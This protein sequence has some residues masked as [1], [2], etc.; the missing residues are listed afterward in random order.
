VASLGAL[1]M[2]LALGDQFASSAAGCYGAVS[3][4]QEE[5]EGE[6]GELKSSGASEPETPAPSV[7]PVFIVKESDASDSQENDTSLSP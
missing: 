1:I 7:T 6:R 4:T 3:E 2:V 5:K